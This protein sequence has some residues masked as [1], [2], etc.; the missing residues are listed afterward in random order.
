MSFTTSEERTLQTIAGRFYE[1]ILEPE[2]WFGALDD[3]RRA[4]QGAL[5]YNVVFD[6]FSGQV[7]GSLQND[8]ST[9]EQMR[10]YERHHVHQDECVPLVM[11]LPVGQPMFG[12]Q[13]FSP[14][15]L[16]RSFIHG[17]W[18]PSLGYRHTFCVPIHESGST[19]ELLSIV[20][21]A[22][23]VDFAQPENMLV[24]RLLPDLLRAARLRARARGLVHQAGWSVAALDA[25]P[26]AVVILDAQA[27]VHYLNTAAERFLKDTPGLS[28]RQN[29]LGAEDAR[30][31]QALRAGIAGACGLDMP[32]RG[33]SLQVGGLAAP[34]VFI[35]ILPLHAQH[36]LTGLSGQRPLALL[37]WG[38]PHALP[39]VT[40]IGMA[41]GLTETE[42]RLALV[43][44]SGKSLK[45]FAQE[46]GCSWHTART[47]VK[48]A[49]AKTGCRRQTDLVLLVRALN[50]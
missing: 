40:Q 29:R 17:E 3:F 32:S 33:T 16:S 11:R 4:M 31:Q 7:A 25:L 47:H 42:A 27:R 48:N 35:H 10:E 38:G 44:A 37:L 18:L 45:H 34:A 30:Q 14:R 21:P 41:L 9:V 8:D 23:H 36:P 46:Q 6:K 19:R 50:A 49:L 13:H 22:D 26:Q 39:P 43:L 2:E 1:G 12:Y 5:F 20:R 24:Q 28:L 15:E